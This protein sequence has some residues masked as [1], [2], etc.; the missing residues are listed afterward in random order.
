MPESNAGALKLT[1]VL[2]RFVA[3]VS[4]GVPVSDVPSELPAGNVSVPVLGLIDHIAEEAGFVTV[5]A[6]KQMPVPKAKIPT[7]IENE[8]VSTVAE[9]GNPRMD[10]NEHE[11]GTG[12]K[13]NWAGGLKMLWRPRGDICAVTH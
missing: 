2:A 5:Q 7:G 9:E 11:W 6:G 13:T 4:R 3:N 12:E 10:T 1:F 8:Y